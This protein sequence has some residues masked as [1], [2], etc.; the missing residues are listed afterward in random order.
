MPRRSGNGGGGRNRSNRKDNNGSGRSGRSQNSPAAPGGAQ[1]GAGRRAAEKGGRDLGE[2]EVMIR[3][4]GLIQ[5]GDQRAAAAQARYRQDNDVGAFIRAARALLAEGGAAPRREEAPARAGPPAKAEEQLSQLMGAM[6]LSGSA[7]GARE[8]HKT[9]FGGYVSAAP[10]DGGALGAPPLSLLGQDFAGAPGQERDQGLLDA[11]RRSTPLDAAAQQQQEA[12]VQR[13]RQQMQMQQVQMQQMQLQQMQLQQMQRQQAQL[14]QRQGQQLQQQQ[15][16]QQQHRLQQQQQQQQLLQRQQ[17]LQSPQRQQ[18]QSQQHHLLQ[19]PQLRQ[20]QHQQQLQQLQKQQL[21]NPQLQQLQNQ[22]HLQQLQ[23]QQLQTQQQ[24]LQNPQRQLQSPQEQ[25]QAQQH[26]RLQQQRPQRQGQE[27][28]Q[29]LHHAPRSPMP[30]VLQPPGG[31]PGAPAAASTPA[32]LFPPGFAEPPAAASPPKAPKAKPKWRDTR[33]QVCGVAIHAPRPEGSPLSSLPPFGQFDAVVRCPLRLLA[34]RRGTLMVALF[35]LGSPSNTAAIVSKQALSASPELRP[36]RGG[37]GLSG[38]RPGDPDLDPQELAAAILA[39]EGGPPA[40]FSVPFHAPKA[41]GRFVVRVYDEDMARI[42]LGTS[43]PWAV[44]VPPPAVANCVRGVLRQAERCSAQGL[45]SQLQGLLEGVLEGG[46]AADPAPRPRADAGSAAGVPHPHAGTG[47]AFARPP[48][49]PPAAP[50]DRRSAESLWHMVSLVRAAVS[51]ATADLD[52]ADALSA[53]L[54]AAARRRRAA[55]DPS[56]H[57]AEVAALAERRQ[58]ASKAERAAR[59]LHRAFGETLRL[60][61]RHRGALPGPPAGRP[62]EWLRLYCPLHERFY[63]SEERLREHWRR[64]V[65]FAPAAGLR[66]GAAA[67]AALQAQVEAKVLELVPPAGWAERREAARARLE[68]LLRAGGAIPEGARLAV[69]G[70][71]A[72]GFGRESSDMDMC[73]VGAGELGEEGRQALIRGVGACLARELGSCDEDPGVEVRDTARIPIVMF[74]DPQSGVDCDISVANPLAVENTRLLRAYAALDPRVRLLAYVVKAWSAARHVN[75]PS[76]ATLSSYG[77]VLMVLCFLQTRDPPVVPN[78]QRAE[79]LRPKVVPHPVERGVSVDLAFATEAPR[80]EP[81][82]ASAAE[83]LAAFFHFYAY[84][85]DYERFCLSLKGGGLRRKDA[86]AEAC[87][88]PQYANLSIEDPFEDFYDVAHVIKATRH[89]YMRVEMARAF[90]RI[91]DSEDGEGLLDAILEEGPLP[92]WYDTPR[93]QQ[94]L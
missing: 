36:L 81:N 62:A 78:L 77:Y 6:A 79:G 82:R 9:L 94:H 8:P 39:G 16:L 48:A 65:G 2:E 25:L 41:P 89:T 90:H 22:Q 87:G 40:V 37:R 83:L 21:Q 52:A 35:R 14:Q 18:L 10:M 11:L 44:R 72:N 13:R 73:V 68:R 43:A 55:E 80:G 57:D 67:L 28:R 92:P 19:S 47:A 32:S 23:K 74:R 46:G 88:W 60:L 17:Q 34:S 75:D 66:A 5:A 38:A 45:A 91:R 12:Q 64:D 58:E 70:S 50:L 49:R 54:A 76:R 1:Q 33:H 85:V 20:L 24:Q 84:E 53:S 59:S 86:K 93:D 61:L 69:F 71:S 7:A 4:H 63:A 56:A 26:H 51:D 30:Q 31:S 29:P 27:P 3:M 42:T 15:R